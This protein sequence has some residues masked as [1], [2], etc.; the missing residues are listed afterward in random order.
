MSSYNPTSFITWDSRINK[1]QIQASSHRW[2]M[3]WSSNIT[4]RQQPREQIMPSAEGG[5]TINTG[6]GTRGLGTQGPKDQGPNDLA[7]LHLA[8]MTEMQLVSMF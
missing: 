6:P 7:L 1:P 8:F 3:G 2:G 4:Y 5:V